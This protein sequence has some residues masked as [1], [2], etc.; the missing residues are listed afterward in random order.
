M[1]QLRSLRVKPTNEGHAQTLCS[2]LKKIGTIKL[3]CTL[4]RPLGEIDRVPEVKSALERLCKSW[5]TMESSDIE[6]CLIRMSYTIKDAAS[7][8][9]LTH[10]QPLER[11]RTTDQ[12]RT[13]TKHTTSQFCA[14][15]HY[16]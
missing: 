4:L 10:G 16:Y 12:V 5:K 14:S 15:S 8:N 13:S 11:V 1:K 9:E 6:G 2:A 3:N 7:L